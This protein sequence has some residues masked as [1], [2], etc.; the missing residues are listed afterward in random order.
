MFIEYLRHY[1]QNPSHFNINNLRTGIVAGA[2]CSEAL[3]TK[4]INV[5]KL[6]DITNC[7]GMT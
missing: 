2:V 5:L 7:Y 3:M 6:I 4:I 1:E